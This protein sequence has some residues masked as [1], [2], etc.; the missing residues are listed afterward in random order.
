MGDTKV[1][2]ILFLLLL[3]VVAGCDGAQDAYRDAKALQRDVREIKEVIADVQTPQPEA[4]WAG[5]ASVIDGDTIEIRGQRFRLH[6]IDAPESAQT[7]VRRGRA[8]RCGKEAAFALA[9]HIGNRNVNC[10]ERDRDRYKRIV[11]VCR[12][13][14]EDLNAWMVRNG[15]AL[16]YR[17]YAPDYIVEEAQARADRA[18]IHAGTFVEPWEYRKQRRR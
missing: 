2:R 14:G 11:A 1:N 17:E 15:W 8:W 10:E 3:I 4:Q 12:A 13:A 7:C 6:G 16:A 18:G 9:D 5:R